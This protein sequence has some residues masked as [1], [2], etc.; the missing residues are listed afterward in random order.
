M[1][2]KLNKHGLLLNLDKCIFEVKEV[3]YLG[4]IVQHNKIHID[5]VKVDGLAK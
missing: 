4:L 5:P 2:K 3:D 1:L